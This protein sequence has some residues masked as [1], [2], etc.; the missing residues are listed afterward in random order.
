MSRASATPG[1]HRSCAV[2]GCATGRSS[3]SSKGLRGSRLRAH[4][5]AGHLDFLVLGA[6]WFT[7]N[8]LVQQCPAL[9]ALQ[10]ITLKRRLNIRDPKRG[11]LPKSPRCSP[12][13][14]CERWNFLENVRC[15]IAMP[16]F[17]IACIGLTSIEMGL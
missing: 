10:P 15:F 14:G 2:R 13:A 1:G 6:E 5:S 7:L 3:G 9:A 11:T 8:G 17:V 12:R 16:L 4:A